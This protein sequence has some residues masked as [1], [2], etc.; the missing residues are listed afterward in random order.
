MNYDKK[1]ADGPHEADHF[2]QSSQIVL[3]LHNG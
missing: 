2:S 3:L 1:Q